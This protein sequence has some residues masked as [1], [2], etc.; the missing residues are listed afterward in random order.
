M[1]Y[2]ELW[3]QKVTFLSKVE[4]PGW[5]SQQC[6]KDQSQGY[7][8]KQIAAGASQ[9]LFGVRESWHR[10]KE[11]GKRPRRA[12]KVQKQACKG[13]QEKESRQKG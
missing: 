5:A 11:R 7:S 2:S 4:A 6:G 8:G 12:G 3:N 10:L 13:G 1:C 9:C